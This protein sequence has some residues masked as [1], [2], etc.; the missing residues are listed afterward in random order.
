MNIGKFP[1]SKFLNI[2]L[3]FDI[4]KSTYFPSDKFSH[5]NGLEKFIN[6]LNLKSKKCYIIFKKKY[7]VKIFIVT[8]VSGSGCNSSYKSIALANS[9]GASE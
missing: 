7:K 9:A 5:L 8:N 1:S 3:K 2:L 4:Q 6:F